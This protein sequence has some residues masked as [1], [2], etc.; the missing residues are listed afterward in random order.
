M[1]ITW[2]K[3]GAADG[4]ALRADRQTA[5]RGRADRPWSS[6]AGNL[7]L[8]V[9]VRP[10]VPSRRYAELAFVA[11]LAAGDAIDGW[12]RAPAR[13][14]LKW[15]NDLLFDGLK[16]G[17][18]LIEGADLGRLVVGI[19]LNLISHP[20][21]S[22]WPATDLAS[23]VATAPAPQAAARDL[24]RAL[25]QRLEDWR[26][27]GFA[28]IRATWLDRAWALG[29]AV[30]VRM[31][32]GIAEGRFHAL[33]DDGAMLLERLPGGLIERVLAADVLRM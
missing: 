26:A 4:T 32:D 14:K 7:H 23:H 17:G 29:Q 18:I 2:A 24:C 10:A 31:A 8:S 16:M 6:P 1:L 25:D 15:P 27:N 11:A 13:L 9:L 28:A 21:D 12:S 33:D 5:G 30:R 20:T 19:G 22:Q 3:A